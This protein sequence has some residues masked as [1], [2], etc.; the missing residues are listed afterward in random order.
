MLNVVIGYKCILFA[1]IK[2]IFC[3]FTI[4]I[5]LCSPKAMVL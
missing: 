3:V 1:N 5:Y 2:N 4:F